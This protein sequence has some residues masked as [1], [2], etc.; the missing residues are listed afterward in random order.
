LY[1]APNI[2]GSSV[3][4]LLYVAPLAPGILRWLLDIW[5]ICATVTSDAIKG[6]GL[7]ETQAKS[8]QYFA[9]GNM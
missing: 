4:N 6:L 8:M 7:I 1:V 3:W 2:C 9:H 5:K